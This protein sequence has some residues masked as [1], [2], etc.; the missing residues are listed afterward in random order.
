MESGVRVG[1]N[2]GRRVD[3]GCGEGTRAVIEGVNVGAAARGRAVGCSALGVSAARAH[4]A[5]AKQPT[6]KIQMM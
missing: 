4:A 6:N 3:E 5:N 1:S 2:V